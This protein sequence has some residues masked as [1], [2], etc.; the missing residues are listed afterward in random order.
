MRGERIVIAGGSGFIG[1]AMARHFAALGCEV[2]VLTRDPAR[3]GGPGEAAAWDGRTLGPWAGRLDGALAVINLT[4]RSVDCRYH[5]RNRREII[6]SRV[7]SVRVLDAAIA[8]CARKPA[9]WVQA[10][11]TAIYGESGDALLDESATPNVGFSPEVAKAWEW[12]FDGAAAPVRKVL[13]RISFVLGSG[14]GAVAKLGTLARLGL[15]GAVG[16]GRQWVS[17]I[18][19]R[20]LCRVAEWAIGTPTASGIYHATG[21]AP[22]TNAQF[23]RAIRR[24]VRRPWSPRTPAWAVRVGSFLMRTEAELALKGRRCVPRRLL[25]EGF[26]FEHT[27]L[28]EV[29]REA[30]GRSDGFAKPQA[31]TAAAVGAGVSAVMGT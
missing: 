16:S 23:M 15:G 5:A 2:V 4:G 21:P 29:L 1:R 25:D 6:E 19:A 9:V 17:W 18:D 3:H 27:G 8:R 31:A 26:R 24:A 10:A 28:D 14:G 22:A 13:L 7:E 30:L 20:D 11:T 12:A